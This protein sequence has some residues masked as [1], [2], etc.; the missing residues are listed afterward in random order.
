[1][2]NTSI[3]DLAFL[4]QKITKTDDIRMS[5][6]QATALMRVA[7]DESFT[8][9]PEITIEL[10]LSVVSDLVDDSRQLSH[11]LLQSLK[12]IRKNNRQA[13]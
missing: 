3:N 8:K 5:L 7:S 11:L 1:M 4:N 12:G 2:A 10:Y 13:P 9:H 6:S